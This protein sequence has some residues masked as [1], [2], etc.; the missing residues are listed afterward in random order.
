VWSADGTSYQWQKNGTNIP[1]ATSAAYTTP[2][3]TL[4]DNGAAYR[5]IVSNAAGSTKSRARRLT[6]VTPRA[7]IVSDELDTAALNTGSGPSSI[8]RRRDRHDVRDPGCLGG[9]RGDG[10]RR[11]GRTGGGLSAP[12]LLQFVPDT[13]FEI[14]T[15]STRRSA[16][17]SSW[18]G[19]LSSRTATTTCA[20]TSTATAPTPTSSPASSSTA[21][22]RTRRQEEHH[23]QRCTERGPS[24]PARQARRRH[25]DPQ[26]LHERHDVVQ[27][28]SFDHP[29]TVTAVG[30]YGANPNPPCDPPAF[31]LRVDYFRKLG[32]P[33]PRRSARIARSD[34]HRTTGDLDD[35]S[36]TQDKAF[37]FFNIRP[38]TPADLTAYAQG[39]LHLRLQ[40]MREAQ[41]P[42]RAGADLLP[43]TRSPEGARVQQLRA[44]IRSGLYTH[45]QSLPSMWSYSVIDWSEPLYKYMLVFQDAI[46][47][48][49]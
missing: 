9:A 47:L 46:G 22:S 1:G 10:A 33:A 26:L 13:D 42:R 4:A 5:C 18:R 39:T 41:H 14:E 25:L 3:T 21:S 30:V 34:I 44:Y 32:A 36:P 38:E 16:P 28:N 8:A 17:T 23:R 24:V 7:A 12:R 20:S 11:H 48:R 15:S 2:A 37:V 19:S 31:S 43:N 45:S 49:R 27:H 40:V 29:M 35:R 6:V